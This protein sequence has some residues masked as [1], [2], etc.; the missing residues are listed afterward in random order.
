MATKA[1]RRLSSLKVRN[2]GTYR[3]S[4]TIPDL[5]K[6][7]TASYDRF[8]Q[9][10]TPANR[11]KNEGLEAVLREIFPIESYDKTLSLDYLR[12]E[13][14][15]PRYEPDEFC[16]NDPEIVT[17]LVSH[18]I[19]AVELKAKSQKMLN[20]LCGIQPHP[21]SIIAG[22][23]TATPSREQ[24]LEFRELWDEQLDFVN[25]V[26]LPDVIAVGTGPLLPLATMGLGAAHGDYLCF[27]MFPQDAP[28]SSADYAL[29]GS[30]HLVGG[31]A[32]LGG[33]LY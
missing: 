21:N 1:L 4:Y 32:I 31:G 23:C 33:W 13:L 2:F 10:G 6:I 16:V 26:Y 17:T 12:Y 14:G 25:N 9:Y 8:L 3:E 28:A 29:G 30:N 18:Y 22:G 5:T 19:K 27:P 7:Q 15:K 20:I 24:L 11:R